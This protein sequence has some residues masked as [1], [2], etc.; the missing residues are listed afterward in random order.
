[1]LTVLPA[2]GC[3][4]DFLSYPILSVASIMIRYGIRLEGAHAVVL[5]R[6][7]TVGLPLT[8]L[9]L[10]RSATVTN[11]DYSMDEKQAKALCKKADILV[12][13]CKQC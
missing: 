11:V 13:V 9:L 8:L 3:C 2:S 5:G 6:S 7:S 12:S 4:L 10:S 1:M